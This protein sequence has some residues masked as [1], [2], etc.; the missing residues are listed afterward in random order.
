MWNIEINELDFIKQRATDFLKKT[1][2]LEQYKKIIV[3][4]VTNN[5][6]AIKSETNNISFY[7]N[8]EWE[9]L[10]STLWIYKDLWKKN[11]L[12]ILKSYDTKKKKIVA[13]TTIW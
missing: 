1:N 7:M 6:F 13:D 10:F 4:K 9:Q 3:V 12:T 5:I 2:E 11:I 8:K